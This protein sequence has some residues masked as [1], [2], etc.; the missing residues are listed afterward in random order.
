MV[1]VVRPACPGDA[2]T[3]AA[4]RAQSWQSTYAA[5]MP[6]DVLARHTSADSIARHARAL[7]GRWPSGL[8]IAEVESAGPAGGQDP[9]SGG[10]SCD[11]PRSSPAPARVAVGFANFGPERG[12]D[13]RPHPADSEPGRSR[14]ELYAIYVLA[15]YW[16]AGAGRALMAEVLDR[17]RAR[18]YA[19]IS[20]WVAQENSRA[21]LFYERAGFG[22]TADSKVVP[23]L[24]GITEIR[25]EMPFARR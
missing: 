6:A 25:Y 17:V 7:R 21:R 16:S 24:G 3:I 5:M 22:L 20:L 13:G 1:V 19:T 8:L 15:S 9:A 12:P 23:E 4:V 10:S 14:A 18:E 2:G 11:A